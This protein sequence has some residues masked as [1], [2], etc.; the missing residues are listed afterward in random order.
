MANCDAVSKDAP[1]GAAGESE[2]TCGCLSLERR[3]AGVPSWPR[4]RCWGSN[5]GPL[6]DVDTHNLKLETHLCS[7]DMDVCSAV[8]SQSSIYGAYFIFIQHIRLS[9]KH[10]SIFLTF[11]SSAVE[12]LRPEEK[13]NPSFSHPNGVDLSE[14]FKI[15]R[16]GG[17]CCAKLLFWGLLLAKALHNM[18]RTN[19]SWYISQRRIHWTATRRHLLVLN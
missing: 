19:M 4:L 10:S 1:D 14:E 15:K 13:R 11:T 3:D 2:E 12:T 18:Q 9:F 5:R 16:F 17:C 6:R 7:N 8:S